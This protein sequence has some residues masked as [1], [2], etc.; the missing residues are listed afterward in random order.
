MTR[1]ACQDRASGETI[2]NDGQQNS[3]SSQSLDRPLNVCLMVDNLARAGVETQL[4]QLIHRMDR[5]AINPHL[6]LLDGTGE[7]SREL[8]PDDCPVIRLGVRSLRRP[9]TLAK[10][11]RFGKY[12]RR[13][14]IDIVHPHFQD[15]MYFAAPIA[16]LVG[17]PRVVRFRVNLGYWMRPIDRRLMRFYNR[18][19][20]ATLVNCIACRDAVIDQEHA[21]PESV[22]I[23]PNG[24]DLP[25]FEDADG[26]RYP[27]P[28]ED[29]KQTIGVVANLRHVKGLDIL[30][31]AAAKL[32]AKHDHVHFVIA[33]EGELRAE[34]EALISE[35]GLQARFELPG[36]I[37]DIPKFLRK[38][39]IAVLCSRSEG[40]P[41]V[42]MEYMAAGKPVVATDVGGV[43]EMVH[44][45][46]TG[47]VVPPES[48]D[49]LAAEVSRLLSD[50]GLARRLAQSARKHALSSFGLEVQSRRYQA[51]YASCYLSRF[52]N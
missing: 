10:A 49:E 25:K 34:L 51:F 52:G 30:I 14:Q 9:S 38:V 29:G 41:N 17:V 23:I 37:D 47:L 24:V 32:A 48:P 2:G 18:F 16:K 33:G 20:D 35:L 3:A 15:S 44:H 12:L 43:A 42:I 45:E 21:P 1:A 26:N 6:C 4:L 31:R 36:R 39:E 50:V 46:E 5:N 8:E 7:E 19:I 40:A 27:P 11:L 28:R 22:S 13:H